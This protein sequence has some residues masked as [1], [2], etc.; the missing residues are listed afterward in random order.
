MSPNLIEIHKSVGRSFYPSVD[1]YL[2]HKSVDLVTLIV[3]VV[4]QEVNVQVY[5]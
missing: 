2:V 3:E 1:P 4:C 5:E